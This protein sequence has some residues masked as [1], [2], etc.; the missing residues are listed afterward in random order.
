MPKINIYSIP[1]TFGWLSNKSSRQITGCHFKLA[2]LSVKKFFFFFTKVDRL[3]LIQM[4]K[5][6]WKYTENNGEC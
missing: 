5:R 6:F 3:F 1:I 2:S 4:V